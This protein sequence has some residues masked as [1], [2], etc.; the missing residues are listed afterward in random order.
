M[1]TSRSTRRGFTLVELLVVVAIIALLIGLLLPAVQKVREAATRMSSANN[2]KQIV[3]AT[4][5][6]AEANN[7][8]LPRA[9]GFEPTRFQFSHH[10]MLLPY[11][12]QSNAY[13][14]F[15][16]ALTHQPSGSRSISSTLQLRIFVSPADFSVSAMPGPEYSICSYPCNAQ[17]FT[18]RANITAIADGNSN[19]IAHAEHYSWGCSGVWFSWL[20]GTFPLAPIWSGT[21]ADPEV[22]ARVPKPGQPLPST[23]FQTRPSLT[24]C[25]PKLAQTPHS[26]GM[27][28]SLLDGSVRV[29]N[30]AV[31]AAT[32]WGAVTPNGGEVL[33]N[34]W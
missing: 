6:Y 21:F 3:L 9:D 22:G 30:P 17:L 34:D 18:L 19:T 32:Y 8:R 5:G 33:G 12:D 11:L 15:E 25:D 16:S 20:G 4:H 24:E 29:I 7:G 23:T 28:V 27:L 2:L 26:G 13:Q 31:S 14:Q 1:D 10:T